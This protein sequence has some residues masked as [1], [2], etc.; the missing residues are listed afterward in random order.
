MTAEPA[1]ATRAVTVTDTTLRDGSHAI[2]HRYTRAHVQTIAAALDRGGVPVIEVTHGDGLGG[3]SLQYGMSAVPELEL[4]SAASAAVQRARIAVLLLPGVGTRD[5]LARAAEHGAQVVRIATHC[6]EADI[7]AQHF[8]YAAE[9]GLEAVGFLMM[10][11][12]LS[13]EELAEQAAL[14]AGYGARSVYVVDSA[15]ALIP[16]G[17]RARVSAVLQAVGGNGAAAGFHAHNNLGLAIGNTVAA[18]EAGATSIDGCLR[19][20]GAGAGNAA[21]ELLAAVLE[22]MGVDAGLDTFALSDAAERDLLPI[23]PFQP[24]PDRESLTIGYAGVYSTFL[25]HAKRHA[26]RLGLD[27]REILVELGRRRAVAGQEDWIVDVAQELAAAR[28]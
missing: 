15:G 3:S 10:A 28:G 18:I 20:F 16:D 11:H 24:F 22:R 21:T 8:G 5:D 6:T 7:S 12:R 23:M 19:G 13:P 9:L 26:E 17:V 25:L 4:I 14:M 1:G 27:P 2:R